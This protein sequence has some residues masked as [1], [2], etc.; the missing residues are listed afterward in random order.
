LVGHDVSGLIA[1]DAA[2]YSRCLEKLRWD[3]ALRQ[4]LTAAAPDFIRNKFSLAKTIEQ[5]NTLYDELM[6]KPRRSRYFVAKPGPHPISEIFLHSQGQDADI[7]SEGD[8][9]NLSRLPKAAFSE[10][11]GSAFHYR[12]FFPEDGWLQNCAERLEHYR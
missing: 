3:D 9:K 8:T 6:A 4:R 10:T 12:R 1:S 7:Y 11:R 5:F 2:D